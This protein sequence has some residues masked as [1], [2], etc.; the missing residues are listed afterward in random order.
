M[1]KEPVTYDFDFGGKTVMVVEDNQISFKLISAILSKVNVE[2]VHA[3]SG[4]KALELCEYGNPLDLILMDLQLPGMNGLETTRK[5][6]SIRPDIP[7]IA[8]SASTFDE[9]EAASRKAG[10]SAYI[11]K[12]LQFKKLL[13]LMQSLFDPKT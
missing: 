11:S 9:L 4:N 7:V 13:E 5:I 10:C 2:I 8:T 6:K 3:N 1:M 12:P